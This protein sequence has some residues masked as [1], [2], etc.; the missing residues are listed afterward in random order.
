M[1]KHR[2]D[3]LPLSNTEWSTVAKALAAI[4]DDGA[5]LVSRIM[6]RVR[7]VLTGTAPVLPQIDPRTAAIR[8]FVSD[9]RRFG[10][11]ADAAGSALLDHGFNTNQVAALAALSIH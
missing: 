10:R 4:E 2:H 11:P 7:V 6:R 8:A 3:P 9:T 5:V 1:K